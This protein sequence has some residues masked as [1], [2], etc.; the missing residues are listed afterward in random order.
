M[1][2][3]TQDGCGCD[4]SPS[5][6][7]AY[8]PGVAFGKAFR[9]LLGSPFIGGGSG[10]GGMHDT[11]GVQFDDYKDV[12]RPEEQIMD[13]SEVTS[14]GVGCVVL[15]EG[16]PGLTSFLLC[17]GHVLLDR[18]FADLD[19]QLQQFSADAFCTP[20][21]VI[22]GHLLDELDGFWQDARLSLLG[23]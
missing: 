2:E 16:V 9:N 20:Q 23:L 17:H 10:D 21:K 8:R 12:Q 13:N 6:R 4:L 11:S 5:R 22:P 18:A 1:V 14:P 19:P 3:S 15:Q 7:L